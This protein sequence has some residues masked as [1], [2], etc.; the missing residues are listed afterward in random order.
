MINGKYHFEDKRIVIDIADFSH[1][2][3]PC[4]EVMK[5]DA[6]TGEELDGIR[7]FDLTVAENVYNRMVKEYTET[8]PPLTGK[9]AK[10]RDDLVT[11]LAAASSAAAS[12]E[13]TGTCNLDAA[14]LL[15]P[16]WNEKLVRQ[17][18]KEAGTSAFSWSAFGGRRFVF[19][20]PSVGQALK[21]EVAAE[22]MTKA[23]SELGYNA[24]CYQ[25]MD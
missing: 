16:R 12:V 8:V 20:P 24:F 9:Y 14:S 17:A 23:L 6:R 11:A 22:A 25:Q 19:T 10:L 18:A 1:N 2:G 4:Y 3:M 15:L 13:D 7:V 5:M 21:N